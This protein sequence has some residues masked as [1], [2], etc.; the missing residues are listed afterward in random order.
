M[1]AFGFYSKALI[2]TIRWQLMCFWFCGSI[3]HVPRRNEDQRRQ[4]RISE[5]NRANLCLFHPFTEASLPFQILS[6]PVA[7]ARGALGSG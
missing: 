6:S 1:P 7:K 2:L 5:Y 3:A 4:I